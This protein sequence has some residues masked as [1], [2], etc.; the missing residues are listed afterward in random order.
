[1]SD[2]AVRCETC[3]FTVETPV[4]RLS[5]STLGVFDDARFPGR[6]VLVL[7]HHAEHFELLAPEVAARFTAD[8]QQAARLIR[9]VTGSRRINYAMLCN[10]VPH[11]HLHLFPRGGAGDT[12]PRV[13]PWELPEP[14]RPLPPERLAT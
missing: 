3:G 12:D 9:E 10:Q 5:A 7:D 4:G 1:M 2:D 13:S 8:V 6:C 14:E 11:L